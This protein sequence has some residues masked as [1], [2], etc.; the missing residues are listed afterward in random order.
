MFGL[1]LG[2]DWLKPYLSEEEK[3]RIFC[4]I[5][6]HAKV[7]FDY[8]RDTYGSGWSTNFYQNHNWINMTGLAAAGYAMQGQAEEA[9][10]YI[11]EAKEDFARV[12]DL[13]AEDGSNYEG[14]TYWRYGGMWLFVYAHLLKVQ[15][16]IDYFQSSP[17]LKNTF[18]YRLYQCNGDFTRQMNYGDCHDRYSSHPVCVY[19]KVAAE[20]RNGHAQK[21]G[22]MVVKEF[23]AQEA[24]NS[25][26]KPGILPEAIF[27]FLWY[28]PSVEEREF[29]DLPWLGILRIWVCWLCAAV[30][31]GTPGCF[32]SSA[33]RREAPSNGG[34]AGRS[35]KTRGSICF[36]C[37][38]ITPTI[39]PIFL[40]AAANISPV[41]TV[42]TAI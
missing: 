31:S 28:D 16:G 32:P 11:K 9:D 13:M 29:D 1:S 3:Q 23:L 15:E 36:L 21:L 39:C 17:Y 40:P 14:V 33:A 24:A 4:K 2:Y 10:T 8:R 27:E 5:R 6:H 37:L 19:Y 26:V 34:K 35:C 41:R 25:K 38:T 22:N 30:G 7:M 18:Y 42:T 12:F 20:Y